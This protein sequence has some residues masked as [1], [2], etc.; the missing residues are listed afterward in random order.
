MSRLC[1]IPRR[2]TDVT[3]QWLSAVLGAVVDRSTSF[4]VGTG[5]TGATYRIAAKYAAN[6]GGCPARS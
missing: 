6:P 4:P 1:W 5:Q 2:P 3:A